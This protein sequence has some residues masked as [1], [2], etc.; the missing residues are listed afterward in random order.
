MTPS[1]RRTIFSLVILAGIG[2]DLV[3]ALRPG[4]PA[5]GL[6]VVLLGLLTLGLAVT[7]WVKGLR[8]AGQGWRRGLFLLAFAA[9]IVYLGLSVAGGAHDGYEG[10][11]AGYNAGAE[12]AVQERAEQ[13][14]PA[15]PAKPLKPNP[16]PVMP[17]GIQLVSW[18]VLT[19][20]FATLLHRLER[21]SAEADH[22]RE[23]AREARSET[24]RS[25]LAPHF[26]FNALNTLHAQIGV[27][28]KG[29]EATT[30]RLADLFRQVVEVSSRTVVPLKQE[31][32]FV[33][34]Y[35]GIEQARLGHR[36]RISIEVPEDLEAAEIP[37][38]SLQVL[39]ENAIKHGVAPLEAG[40]EVRIGAEAREGA[41][42]LWVEDPG[43]GLSDQ[44]GT[45]TALEILRQ[46]LERPED[47]VMGMQGGRHRV[48][49]LWRQA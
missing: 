12:M 6:L 47:L 32:A 36:L 46:R 8:E 45:G 2:W 26:I 49:F 14:Q 29:A 48:S 10:F 40:G 42:C 22:Q 17:P 24:L 9:P 31:L 23:L 18:M 38:L 21:R 11:Q 20:I 25:K 44:R 7:L 41:L 4:P 30:E 13:G 37:P 27:D 16:F 19:A 5:G 15:R 39:V 3:G 33:E 34:A 35:L 1:S 43:S 28:P